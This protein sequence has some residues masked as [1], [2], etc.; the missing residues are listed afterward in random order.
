MSTSIGSIKVYNLAT[1]TI[2]WEKPLQQAA[3]YRK[4]KKICLS[5]NTV[6]FPYICLFP[7]RTNSLGNFAQ[8]FF[9]PVLYH[10][11]SRVASLAQRLIENCICFLIDLVTLPIRMITS[12]PRAIYNTQQKEHRL[13][14]YLKQHGAP[15]Q[16][17]QTDH[18]Q[19]ELKCDFGKNSPLKEESLFCLE[20]RS[21][22][23]QSG[24]L[25]VHFGAYPLDSSRGI[26]IS[27]LAL[28]YNL[29][30]KVFK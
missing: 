6:N 18:V 30:R 4:L 13:L 5:G 8:D 17:T 29:Q 25:T 1:P 10:R 20:K 21:V 9:F 11:A 23:A 14:T 12:I 3:D 19:V 28:P 27:D 26:W 24:Q 15:K 7:V 2:V 22:L 16:L